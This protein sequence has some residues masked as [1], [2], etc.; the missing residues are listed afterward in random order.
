MN[1]VKCPLCFSS[2]VT[3][4]SSDQTREVATIHCFA[5]GKEAEI[6]TEDFQVDTGDLPDTE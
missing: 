3:I 5:C 6:D 2:N 4:V 1:Q